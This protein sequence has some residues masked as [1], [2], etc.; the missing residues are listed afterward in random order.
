MYEKFQKQNEQAMQW[1]DE[2]E[3]KQMP[4]EKI[5]QEQ[6]VETSEELNDLQKIK[7]MLL[8]MSR[9][10]AIFQRISVLSDFEGFEKLTKMVDYFSEGVYGKLDE[11]DVDEIEDAIDEYADTIE[12]VFDSIAMSDYTQK[13]TLSNQ[14]DFVPADLESSDIGTYYFDMAF[15]ALQTFIF[16][17]QG[18]LRENAVYS[19]AELD[20][21]V[22]MEFLACGI[23]ADY[24][25]RT[26]ELELKDIP[27]IQEETACIFSDY[28]FV[29]SDPDSI[30][31]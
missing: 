28:D 18:Q 24:Y 11:K 19:A 14:P 23:L 16:D 30:L 4:Y 27:K 2:L 17:T 3:A 10:C 29:K 8:T 15:S 1:I 7:W 21:S 6:V 31:L 22:E 9:F 5:I 13:I 20:D 12:N 25:Y 26:S